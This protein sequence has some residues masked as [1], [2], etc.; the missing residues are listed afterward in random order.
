ML[1]DG[2]I[3]FKD[4]DK[5]SESLACEILNI[6]NNSIQLNNDFK[7][8]LT[9]GN[10]ILNTYKILSNSKSD[11]SKWHVYLGDERCISVGDKDRN[12]NLINQIWL[13]NS[14]I[15]KKNIHF[16]HAELGPN[17][18][19]LHYN[20]VLSGVGDFDVVLLSMGE[21]GHVASLFPD[22]HHNKNMDVVAEYNSPKFPK[23]RVTMS[24]SR[25]NRST[26]VF[27]IISGHSKKNTVKRYL[28]GVLLPIS[29]INAKSETVYICI[30]ALQ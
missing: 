19:A 27:K 5:L 8:V 29:Q 13:K 22:R 11:W 16:I 9:G 3:V 10:S 23:E 6:A 25:L 20:E 17:D 2:W 28:N 7:I 14:I 21:D 12:D 15:P 18:G 26:N 4:I 30:D 24:Y 1:R